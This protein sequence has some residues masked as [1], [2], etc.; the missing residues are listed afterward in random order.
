MLSK[1]AGIFAV[2]MLFIVPSTANAH[3][4]NVGVIVSSGPITVTWTWIAGHWERG[5]YVRSH[6]SHPNH[7]KNYR[8]HR[9][10]PPPAHVHTPPPRHKHKPR[11]YHRS[12]HGR[13]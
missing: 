2:L 9:H 1:I 4:T 11:H 13:R 12:N 5:R 10:G 8:A 6:W 3:S 7:G